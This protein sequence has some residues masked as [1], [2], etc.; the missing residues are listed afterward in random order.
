MVSD[1]LLLSPLKEKECL[2]SKHLLQKMGFELTNGRPLKCNLKQILF[3]HELSLF[4]Q[5]GNSFKQKF[6]NVTRQV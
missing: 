1:W 4:M 5:R 3:Q 6:Q 2:L